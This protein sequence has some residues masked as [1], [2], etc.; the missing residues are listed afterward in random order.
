MNQSENLVEIINTLESIKDNFE[1]KIDAEID[2]IKGYFMINKNH[3]IF[4]LN[5]YVNVTK[6]SS[7]Q[8]QLKT[9]SAQA[10]LDYINDHLNNRKWFGNR[11]ISN[12]DWEIENKLQKVVF[13]LQSIEVPKCQK[14][15]TWTQCFEN[16]KTKSNH[17][18]YKCYLDNYKTNIA[19]KKMNT[20]RERYI[21]NQ[22]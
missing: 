11:L 16:P 2:G 12:Q 8:K 18:C 22:C 5:F 21:V 4:C 1:T 19:I 7:N 17:Y 14:C 10:V 13:E 9:N 15:N 20:F 3:N 6:C